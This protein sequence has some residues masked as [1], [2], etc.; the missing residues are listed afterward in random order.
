MDSMGL[1]CAGWGVRIWTM[2]RGILEDG[3]MAV[4]SFGGDER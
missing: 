4:T 1:E 3:K 2:E